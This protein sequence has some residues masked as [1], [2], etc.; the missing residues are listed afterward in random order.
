MKVCVLMVGAARPKAERVI[1]NIRNNVAFFT[2]NYPNHT[3]EFAICTYKNESFTAISEFC[4]TNGVTVHPLEPINGTDIPK[5]LDGL[6]FPSSPDFSSKNRYR[7]FYSM[8]HVLSK[9][10]NGYDC[11]IR[12]RIDTEIKS[13]ELVDTIQPATYYTVID[14]VDSCSDN[15]GYGNP[16]VMKKVW[17]LDNCFVKAN[18]NEILVFKAIQ[19]NLFR[20]S[21]FKFRYVMYQDDS[22]FFDGVRQW[23]RRN[24]EWSYDGK[25]YVR[26]L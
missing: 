21:Q 22:E 1:E 15:I 13:F 20:I 24:R 8:S 11:I 12:L 9:I 26:G 23:S 5:V 14:T 19:K 25:T 17:E 2:K 16:G 7:L 10:Q 18:N 6:V 4:E 3:F